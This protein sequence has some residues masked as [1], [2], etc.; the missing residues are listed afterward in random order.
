MQKI[1]KVLKV[2]VAASLLSGVVLC[3]GCARDG[4]LPVEE[5]MV[6]DAVGPDHV[7]VESARAALARFQADGKGDRPSRR[8]KNRYARR[9]S[10]GGVRSGVFCVRNGCNGRRTTTIVP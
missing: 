4:I 10:D 8:C 3:G 9:H 7:S 1:Y 5:P 6:S 2:A